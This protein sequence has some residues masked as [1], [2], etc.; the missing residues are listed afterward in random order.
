MTLVL[1]P[2]LVPELGGIDDHPHFGH[3]AIDPSTEINGPRCHQLIGSL[4]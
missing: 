2:L 4:D 1:A 3:L